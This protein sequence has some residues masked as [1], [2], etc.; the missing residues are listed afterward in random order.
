MDGFGRWFGIGLRHLQEHWR[1]H[2]VPGLVMFGIVMVLVV[3]VFGFA[4]MG[5]VV[6]AVIGEEELGML[7]TMVMG[8]AAIVILPACMAPIQLGYM[9]GTLNL[10]RGGEFGAGDLFSGLRDAPAAIVVMVVAIAAA[11]TGA[12]FCY[13]PAFLVAAL[14]FHALPS[15]ADNGGGPIAALK[16]SVDLAKKN[17]WGL[18]LYVVVYG[19]ALGI[20]GYVPIL[21]AVA[22]IPVGTVL[23]LAPYLDSVE[24]EEED[25]ETGL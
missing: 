9:R 8:T 1:E 6:G 24:R 12:L 15:L 23:A 18:V 5:F 21:G 7:L 13:F 2:V 11:M 14:F 4:G 22:A 25:R 17:Y 16:H 20:L 10:M 19:F 3:V